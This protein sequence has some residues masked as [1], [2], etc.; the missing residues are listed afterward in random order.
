MG[1]SLFIEDED[2]TVVN[3]HLIPWDTKLSKPKGLCSFTEFC[4]WCRTVAVVV[5]ISCG[6]Q[7]GEQIIYQ[8][9]FR[10][11]H[12]VFKAWNM[13]QIP[14]ISLDGD[15][16]DVSCEYS[17]LFILW[18][19]QRTFYG[20]GLTSFY[21]GQVHVAVPSD[22]L[23]LSFWGKYVLVSVFLFLGILI[24]LCPEAEWGDAG[25]FSV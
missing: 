4:L 22:F 12:R 13:R 24:A 15:C 19:F 16:L 25:W 10:W 18:R 6:R 1:R 23:P 2:E 5:W 7:A 17:F 8:M 14:H 3:E 21:V 20:H 11:Y 9:G